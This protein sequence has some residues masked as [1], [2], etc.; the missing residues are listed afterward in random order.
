MLP[1]YDRHVYGLETLATPDN[2]PPHKDPFDRINN[3][4]Q[5]L[6]E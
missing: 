3:T 6:G 1:V 5:V 2:A 4:N